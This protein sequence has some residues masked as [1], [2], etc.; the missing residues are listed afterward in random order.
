[1]Q[2]YL[3][4]ILNAHTHTF[5]IILSRR[6]VILFIVYSIFLQMFSVSYEKCLQILL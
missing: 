1:M 4:Y 5:R 2:T 3:E 6:I